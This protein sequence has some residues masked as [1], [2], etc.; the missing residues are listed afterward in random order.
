MDNAGY[1]FVIHGE[2]AEGRL[3]DNTRFLIDSE[4]IMLVSQYRFHLN[5]KGYIYTTRSK[6]KECCFF[7]HW[8][9]LGYKKNPGFQIDHINRDKTD[10]RKKNLRPVS[11]QQNAMNRGLMKTNK[12]GYVGAFYYPPRGYYISRICINNKRI[13]LHHSNNLIE[14]AQAYNIARALLFGEFGGQVNDVP[15]PSPDLVRTVTD[16]CRPYLQE[17][18]AALKPVNM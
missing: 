17:A 12:S 9:V 7:L 13:A 14:C 1:E 2:Y 16:K 10:C 15:D 18:E 8:L 4:D 11:N 6:E 3:P 5:W